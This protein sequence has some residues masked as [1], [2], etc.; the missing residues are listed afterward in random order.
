MTKKNVK[1]KLFFVICLEL[2]FCNLLFT[3]PVANAFSWSNIFPPI[4]MA[5]IPYNGNPPVVKTQEVGSGGYS[6]ISYPNTF[7]K[8]IVCHGKTPVSNSW[9][10]KEENIF[11]SLGNLINTIFKYPYNANDLRGKEESHNQSNNFPRVIQSQFLN[12]G[13]TLIFDDEIASK[14]TDLSM[15][16][17]GIFS[18]VYSVNQ[19]RFFQSEALKETLK[20]LNGEETNYSDVQRGWDC[21]GT[22]EPLDD[23]PRDTTCRPITTLEVIHYYFH[24]PKLGKIFYTD[25]TTMTPE[26]I[27]GDVIKKIQ[28]EYKDRFN[29]SIPTLSGDYWDIAFTKIYQQ[30]PIKALGPLGQQVTVTNYKNICNQW[31]NYNPCE[32]TNKRETRNIA[33]LSPGNP[34]LTNQLS[35]INNQFD[36]DLGAGDNGTDVS[37][38]FATPFDCEEVTVRGVPRDVVDKPNSISILTFALGLYRAAISD[39][40]K[41]S[42]TEQNP[43]KTETDANAVKSATQ[44]TNDLANMLPAGYDQAKELYDSLKNLNASSVVK[45]GDPVDVGYQ[46]AEVFNIFRSYLHPQSWQDN[47]PT[48]L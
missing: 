4:K 40:P 47:Y 43:K 34:K 22:F 39:I 5:R 33:F 18:K 25:P 26:P 32:G 19:L 38:Q 35:S 6:R 13:A 12:R 28:D 7:E 2:V 29:K 3:A 1:W 9:S 23:T 8:V 42:A 24:N 11:D 44:I 37:N 48:Q 31:P 16:G 46:A 10:A 14:F 20:T 21:N 41:Y 17:F 15:A 27:P 45:K 36:D 30:L